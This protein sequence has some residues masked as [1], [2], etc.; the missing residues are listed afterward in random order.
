M[1]GL[2]DHLE[3]PLFFIGTVVLIKTSQ[4]GNVQVSTKQFNNCVIIRLLLH[5]VYLILYHIITTGP[6]T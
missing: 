6:P 5:N 3:D 2:P 1:E 4:R